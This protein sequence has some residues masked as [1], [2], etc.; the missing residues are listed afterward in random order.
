M[1][2][3]KLHGSIKLFAE[4]AAYWIGTVESLVIHSIL[5][6]GMLCLR[7]FGQSWNDIWL[8]ITTAVSVE[9]IYLAIFI[10]MAVNDLSEKE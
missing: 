5:F 6:I 1:K 4:K 8:D 2:A 7:L 9:A 10:Q 3:H